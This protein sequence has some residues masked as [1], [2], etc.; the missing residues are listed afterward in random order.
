VPGFCRRLPKGGFAVEFRPALPLRRTE[1][2]EADIRANTI[3]VNRVLEQEILAH[4]EQWLWLHRRWKVQQA[5]VPHAESGGAHG[6][7]EE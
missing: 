7:G 1:N 5:P 2:R 6:A 3:L 4:P